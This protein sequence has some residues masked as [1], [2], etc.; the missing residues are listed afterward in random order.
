MVNSSS[1]ER[2]WSTY[3]YIHNVKRYNLNE[4]RA[5]GLVYVDYNL[6]LLTCYYEPIKNNTPNDIKWDT[7]SE[8]DNVEDGTL[9][10]EHLQEELLIDDDGEHGHA[11]PIPRVQ[12]PLPSSN[13]FPASSHGGCVTSRAPLPSP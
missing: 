7:N 10:L 4:N 9:A 11:T 3:S 12:M 1:I 2:C 6:R 8:E 13:S 5:E